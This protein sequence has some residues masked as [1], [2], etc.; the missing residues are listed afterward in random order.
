MTH[1]AMKT[2]PQ[3]ARRHASP[4]KRGMARGRATLG[5]AMD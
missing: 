4:E 3:R 1:G 5:A 2:Y